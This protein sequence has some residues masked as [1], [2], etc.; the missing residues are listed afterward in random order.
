MFNIDKLSRTPIYEQ[1]ISNIEESI[2]CGILEV[3]T[4]IPSVREL[5]CVISVNP[6]TIQKAYSDLEQRGI[7][8]SVPGVGR[9][10]SADAISILKGDAEKYY[11][12]LEEDIANLKLHGANL[13]DILSA[14]E[15][16]Y[17]EK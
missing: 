11:S 13:C 15:R 3:E 14:V 6:N 5:S 17:K 12:R 16:I 4:K 2:L 10:V 8:K 7:T 1:L 9:F